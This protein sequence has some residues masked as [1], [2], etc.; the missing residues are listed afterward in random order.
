MDLDYTN[1]LMMW[2]KIFKHWE[3]KIKDQSLWGS[4]IQ[5]TELVFKNS[6]RPLVRTKEKYF[7]K[8][9]K[10][11]E[12]KEFIT[13]SKSN[14]PESNQTEMSTGSNLN[15]YLMI[16]HFY[17]IDESLLG[18]LQRVRK[19]PQNNDYCQL[20]QKSMMKAHSI[21]QEQTEIDCLANKLG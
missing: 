10:D 17:C 7:L 8:L 4:E 9:T 2:L 21:L 15:P 14:L 19:F 16:S 5:F 11:L 13:I 20:H 12:H 18:A 1:F 3:I 6:K